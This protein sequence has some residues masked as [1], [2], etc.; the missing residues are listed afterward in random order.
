[1]DG[2][3]RCGEALMLIGRIMGWHSIAPEL[4]ACTTRDGGRTLR[5]TFTCETRAA[6]S[7]ITRN[8]S[9]A[10]SSRG[11]SKSSKRVS[12]S[13]MEVPFEGLGMG[14]RLAGVNPNSLAI[15]VIIS[16]WRFTIERYSDW[17]GWP[18]GDF[19]TVPYLCIASTPSSQIAYAVQ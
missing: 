2:T 5:P 10:Y 8:S 13:S 19:I 17:T 4:R 14:L 11:R 6:N 1:M 18:F 16:T 7:E 3:R 12:S 15:R 9:L